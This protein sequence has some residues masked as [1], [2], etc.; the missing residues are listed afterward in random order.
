MM[1]L[2]QTECRNSLWINKHGWFVCYVNGETTIYRYT[3]PHTLAYNEHKFLNLFISTDPDDNI[4]RLDVTEIFRLS[5]LYI[6]PDQFWFIV[7]NLNRLRT[8]K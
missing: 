6:N 1:L 4:Q 2:Y 5:T 7:P 8:F 3:L